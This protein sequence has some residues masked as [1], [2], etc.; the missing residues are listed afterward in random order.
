MKNIAFNIPGKV[1]GKGRPRFARRGKFVATYTPEKT[2][3]MESIVKECAAKE[4]ISKDLLTGPV[5]LVIRVYL[6]HPQRWSKKNKDAAYWVIGKPDA[7]NIIKL[8]GDSLNGIV[9][10]DD[11]QVA[12]IHFSRR[13]TTSPEEV[14]VFVTELDNEGG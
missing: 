9:F 4:M 3:A 5:S 1:S 2:K 6:H 11:S 12:S 8:I 14:W 13:Y 7:D 10:T